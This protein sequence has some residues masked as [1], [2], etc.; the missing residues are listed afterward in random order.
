M[1]R[2][3]RVL[4]VSAD[5]D[6]DE[7]KR[8]YREKVQKYHPDLSEREDAEEQFKR[9]KQA[10]DALVSDEEGAASATASSARRWGEVEVAK[11]YH[12]GWTLVYQRARGANE[13]R[14]AVVGQG[15]DEDGFRYINDRGE[16]Q[17]EPFF[18]AER[19]DAE[20]T[21]SEFRF[22]RDGSTE[23]TSGPTVVFDEDLD[24]LWNLY[25]A[26]GDDGPEG[27]LV[28]ARVEGADHYVD[29]E[30]EHQTD[31]HWFTDRSD[32]MDAYHEYVGAEGSSIGHVE[33]ENGV[34]DGGGAT[35]GSRPTFMRFLDG[36]YVRRRAIK[37]SLV[38]AGVA[39]LA[40][41]LGALGVGP[42]GGEG[43]VGQVIA[44]AVGGIGEGLSGLVAID[45]AA[46]VTAA[47]GRLRRSLVRNEDVVLPVTAFY[48]TVAGAY[49][50][51]RYLS[52]RQAES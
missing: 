20:R 25:R 30:G 7:I 24:T 39:I 21:Y 12:T 9:V 13:R 10:Y 28:G 36:V 49:V 37:R 23:E 2:H 41:A 26:E 47:G 38:V 50:V 42:A 44:D 33:P 51:H 19:E 35:V 45:P 22:E 31:P 1:D 27:W 43:S 8:A 6:D 4:G 3:R 48:V 29:A 40:Y 52:R 46:A 11:D 15:R 16:D 18:F 34:A 17:G 14:W 5:A 32:A